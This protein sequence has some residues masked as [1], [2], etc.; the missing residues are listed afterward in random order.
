ML[1]V[2]MRKT[3]LREVNQSQSLQMIFF[4]LTH[5][6]V[7]LFTI[8]FRFL[9]HICIHM[10]YNLGIN[11]LTEKNRTTWNQLNLGYKVTIPMTKDL[12]LFFLI[13]CKLAPGGRSSK[14]DLTVFRSLDVTYVYCNGLTQV[15]IWAFQC[16]D[17][18]IQTSLHLVG[19]GLSKWLNSWKRKGEGGKE[20]DWSLLKSCLWFWDHAPLEVLM[21]S[22]QRPGN[23][24][25]KMHLLIL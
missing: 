17:S 3:R 19:N 9:V 10:R 15:D 1:T 2:Q 22:H 6:S 12:W 14:S 7:I 4:F 21:L 5:K 11:W 25:V 23:L 8:P 24:M 13:Y 20:W 16:S 18:L